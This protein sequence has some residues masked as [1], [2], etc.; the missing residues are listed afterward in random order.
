M[1]RYPPDEIQQHGKEWQ[2]RDVMYAYIKAQ[3][4]NLNTI[5]AKRGHFLT[6]QG[7]R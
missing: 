6:D 2:G 1:P 7:Q 5:R 4:K 3:A